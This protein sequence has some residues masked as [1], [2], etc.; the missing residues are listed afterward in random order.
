MTTQ[1]GKGDRDR[2]TNRDKYRR[3]MERI[4][5]QPTKKGKKK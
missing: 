1:N 3:E 5:R 4:F 2:T